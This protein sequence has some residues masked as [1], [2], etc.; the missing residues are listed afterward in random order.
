MP[1]TLDTQMEQA[2]EALARMDYLACESLCEAALGVAKAQRDWAYYSRILLPLQESRRQRRMVA[3]EGV[4]RLG[5]GT[6]G[7]GVSI[8][9]N[10]LPAG[11]LVV[12][13]PHTRAEAARLQREA[14]ERRLFVEV[15][16][17]ESKSTDGVWRIGTFAGPAASIDVP[18]PPADCREQWLPS[19]T[20]CPA[21]AQWFLDASEKLGDVLLA[22]VT[23]TSPVQRVDALEQCLLGAGDHEILHQRLADAAND[24]RLLP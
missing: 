12:T 10:H 15:L 23:A 24:A 7:G 1:L 13:H 2:S 5:T 20:A 8:W 17:A 21:A 6:E 9:L 11:C 18:A 22:R 16:L 19:G 14:R 4:I 3:A